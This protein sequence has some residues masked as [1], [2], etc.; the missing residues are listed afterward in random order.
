VGSAIIGALVVLKQVERATRCLEWNMTRRISR[1]HRARPQR[2]RL[3]IDLEEMCLQF[4]SPFIKPVA[5][6]LRASTH[7]R[8]EDSPLNLANRD[9]SGDPHHL[10]AFTIAQKAILWRSMLKSIENG[11]APRDGPRQHGRFPSARQFFA[12]P[13][14]RQDQD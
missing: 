2:N 3:D 9:R 5:G 14:V 4:A 12:K 1:H 11:N 6:D 10:R 8:G 13:S 7:H